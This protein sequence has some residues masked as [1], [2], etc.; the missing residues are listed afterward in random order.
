MVWFSLF[1]ASLKFS[2]K[3]NLSLFLKNMN[4][5]PSFFFRNEMKCVSTSQGD[6]GRPS[7]RRRYWSELTADGSKAAAVDD[8]RPLKDRRIGTDW[9][10]QAQTSLRAASSVAESPKRFRRQDIGELSEE[11][12]AIDL[13][14]PEPPSRPI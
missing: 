12:G 6:L 3:T 4:F 5:W 7:L 14:S 2:G 1:L 13:N 10:V 11:S 8:V 9:P